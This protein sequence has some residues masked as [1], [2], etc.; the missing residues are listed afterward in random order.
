MKPQENSSKCRS[1][2]PALSFA[3]SRR[4]EKQRKKGFG[5]CLLTIGLACAFVLGFSLAVLSADRPSQPQDGQHHRE[6]QGDKLGTVFP[7]PEEPCD[8]TLEVLWGGIYAYYHWKQPPNDEF[9]NMRFEMPSDYGGRLDKIEICFYENGSSGTPDLDL[10][11]WL[12]DGLYPLDNNPPDQAIASFHVDYDSI[13]WYPYYTVMET[14]PGGIEFDLHQKFHIG[15]S[16]A[17]EP[18]DTLSIL[19][20]DGAFETDRSSGWDGS[21]WEDYWPYELYINAV[22]CPYAPEEST[23]TIWCSPEENSAGVGLPPAVKYQVDVGSVLGYSL[24]VDLDCTPPAGINVSFDP[25]NVPAPYISDVTISVDVGT[26]CGDDTLTFCGTGADGQGPKCH[27]VILTV[28]PPYDEC[29]VEFFHGKQRITNFGA[30]GDDV[31]SQNF[32]WHGMDFLYDG[33]F[34]VATGPNNMALDF[35]TTHHHTGWLPTQPMD[36]YFDP[37]WPANIGYAEF[38][39][40]T[41][42]PGEHDS[43]FVVG[44]MDSCVDFSIKIKIYY[45]P[46]PTPIDSM[47]VAL[48]EDWD[49]FDALNNWGN[50]DTLHNL[51]WMY[52]PLEPEI[53]CGMFKVPFHDELMFNMKF[54]KSSFYVWPPLGYGLDQDSLWV[55]ISTPGYVYPEHMGQ[56]RDDFCLLI[57]P[58]AIDLHEGDANIEIWIDFGRDLTDGLSWSQWWHRVLRYAGF[59][60]GD[61]DASDELDIS[62]VIYLINYL[63][64][65]GA[66]PIPYADQGDVNADRMVDV[67]DLVYLINYLFLDGSPPTDYVRFIPSMWG[68]PSLFANPLWQ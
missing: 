43:V 36:C 39:S 2:S 34:I 51:M 18:G 12:S 22:I 13:T 17:H 27:D 67:A 35:G 55:L 56:N 41:S 21:A 68:R 38:Y 7:L 11:V 5:D 49:V 15:F 53:V 31:Q 37:K 50:M 46:T 63:F 1:K 26:P 25:D 20:D 44:I 52:D 4:I 59:Y 61:A 24:N 9:L 29:V 40:D 10:Y 48:F 42:I 62:D 6:G 65:N 32:V 60:R 58:G 19:S 54:V 45:N 64:Q 66:A 47:F 57:T 16:H 3:G 28:Q 23:F 33:T 30:V 14:W 8:T